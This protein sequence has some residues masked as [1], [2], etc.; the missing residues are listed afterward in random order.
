MDRVVAMLLLLVLLVVSLEEGLIFVL[1]FLTFERLSCS[2]FLHFYF[3]LS[4]ECR[5]SLSRT[6]CSGPDNMLLSIVPHLYTLF[7]YR[8]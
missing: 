7:I 4:S 6:I 8:Q 1:F 2:W 3:L 5:F